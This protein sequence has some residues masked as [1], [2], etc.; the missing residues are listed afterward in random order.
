MIH[1]QDEV[2]E[3]ADFMETMD[4][5]ERFAMLVGD[6][7]LKAFDVCSEIAGTRKLLVALWMMS[8]KFL[9]STFQT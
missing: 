7:F 9:K 3:F 2:D 6:A 4:K 5:E 8:N 1:E